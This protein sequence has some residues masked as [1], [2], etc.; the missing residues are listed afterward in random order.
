MRTFTLNET[1]RALVEGCLQQNR[2]SQEQLYQR[3]KD[4]MYTL[5]YR[6]TQDF[7]LAQDVLQEAFLAVFRGIHSF[8]QES[9]LG[10]WIKTI[11]VRTAY[12]K[13]K[14]QAPTE[15]LEAVIR[16]EPI[17]WGDYLDAEYLEQAI[18]GLPPGYRSVFVLIEIEGYSHKEVAATLGISVGTSKSQLY[19]AKRHLQRTIKALGIRS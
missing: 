18:Q 17:D 19:Y 15:S 13:V 14:K 6:I 7:E 4:A 8:R 3:Y 9:T 1:E 5:S 12:K 2:K 10:A 16:Q 11:V